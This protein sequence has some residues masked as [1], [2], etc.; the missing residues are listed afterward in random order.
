MSQSHRFTHLD[1]FD[2]ER[3]VLPTKKNLERSETETLKPSSMGNSCFEN[4]ITESV[5]A[6]ADLS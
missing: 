1:D 2:H 5:P 3:D 6:L 4:V